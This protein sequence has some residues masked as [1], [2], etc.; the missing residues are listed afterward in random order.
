MLKE[1][2]MRIGFCFFM[3]K[4]KIYI[5]KKIVCNICVFIVILEEIRL[6]CCGSLEIVV[7]R[8]FLNLG[9]YREVW[10]LRRRFGIL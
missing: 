7:E 2:I 4:I 9:F 3:N 10:F 5:K 6:E 8:F 1:K